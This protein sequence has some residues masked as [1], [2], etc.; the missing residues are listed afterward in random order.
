VNKNSLFAAGSQGISNNNYITE[1]FRGLNSLYAE[2]PHSKSK[3]KQ[4]KRN[5]KF[6]KIL[7]RL[8]I[9]TANIGPPLMMGV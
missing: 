6:M 2:I 5:L 8:Q 3:I 4:I 1:H 7:S 9:E